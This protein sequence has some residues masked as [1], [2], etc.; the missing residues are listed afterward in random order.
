MWNAFKQLNKLDLIQCE[1]PRFI[2]V[3]EEGC[4]PLVDALRGT[5][6]APQ[7]SDVASS[8]TGM[9]VPNPPDGDWLLTILRKTN[10]TAFSV[11]QQ[12]FS[13]WVTYSH[14]NK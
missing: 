12:N 11:S 10:G 9:R 5:C 14:K 7:E 8:P 1:L 6:F 4:T 2:S 13:E 3:Q